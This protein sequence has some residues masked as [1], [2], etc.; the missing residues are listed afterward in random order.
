MLNHQNQDNSK[1]KIS[2]YSDSQGRNIGPKIEQ[3]NPEK[4]RVVGS[5]MPNAG[6]IQVAET[7]LH[8]KEEIITI[9]GGTND[10]LTA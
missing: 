6:L 9:I 4:F 7:A 5:V 1:I 8:C 3:S 10:T 2:V